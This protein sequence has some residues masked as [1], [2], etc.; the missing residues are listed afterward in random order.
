M[1]VRRY[2]PG[3]EEELWHLYYHTT[4]RIVSQFYTKEQ[5]ERWAPRDKDMDAWKARIEEKNPFI[6]VDNRV[7]IGFAELDPDGHVDNFYTHHQWQG[8]GVGSALYARV[9]TEAIR[10]KLPFLY[11]EVSLPAKEFF[12]KQGFEILKE[13]HNIVC[14]SPAPNFIMKKMLPA[15]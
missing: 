9:E 3:E 11:A 1:E 5:V 13:Q 6:A 4:H 7:I 12:L 2:S 15:E 10:Q 14:G 8:K